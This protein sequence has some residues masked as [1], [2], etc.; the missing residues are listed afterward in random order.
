MHE[1]DTLPGRVSL[2]RIALCCRTAPGLGCGSRAKPIL[3]ELERN[4]AVAEAWLNRCGTLLAVVGKITY[5][6]FAFLQSLLDSH[7]LAGK[8]VRGE[9]RARALEGFL[10]GAGWYRGTEVDRLSEKEAEIIAARLVRR[11]RAR[12]PLSDEKVEALR[13]AFAQV[14]THELIH[15]PA[16]PEKARRDRIACEILEAG[17]RHL[18]VKEIASL[19][20]VVAAGYRPLRGEE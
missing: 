12:L 14:C 1:R 8:A 13:S 2:Y 9:E 19:Q 18:D 20:D 5:P 10:S 15:H 7:G 4:P 16:K 6:R 3:L 17:R 11:L